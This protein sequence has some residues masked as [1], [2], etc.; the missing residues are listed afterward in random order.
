M[1]NYQDHPPSRASLLP[2]QSRDLDPPTDEVRPHNS[3][4]SISS[5][6]DLPKRRDTD[7]R[8]GGGGHRAVVAVGGRPASTRDPVRWASRRQ[9]RAAG[10]L[11]AGAA[12]QVRGEQRA[13]PRRSMQSTGSL[14]P[15]PPGTPP[16]I[17]GS[18]IRR[19]GSRARP[20]DRDCLGPD[21]PTQPA[22]WPRSVLAGRPVPFVTPVT[23]GCPWWRLTHG[24]DAQPTTNRCLTD[25][26]ARRPSP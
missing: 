8:G 21:Q 9:H 26:H 4:W 1:I 22:G 15:R 18:R 3:I 24:S 14:A 19:R 5:G 12:A 6:A 23:A 7:P 2:C 11:V 25:R 10:R 17:P 16:P 13:A 20:A